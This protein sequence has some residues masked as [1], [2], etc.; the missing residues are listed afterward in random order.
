MTEKAAT[1][2][3]HSVAAGASAK[4]RVLTW[5]DSNLAVLFNVPTVVLLAGLVAFPTVLVIWTSLTDWQLVMNQEP[6]F[7]GLSNYVTMWQEERWLG[8]IFNTFYYAIV[9]LTGQFVLGMATALL[10]N[11]NFAGKSFY[12]SIWMMPMISM[13]VAI[14]LVW[15]IMFNTTYGMLNFLLSGLGVPE[16][17]WTADPLIV[18][19]SLILVGIWQWTPFMT[20][21]LLAGLQSLP[22]DP[23]EAAK[24]DG[25]SKWRMLI[26]ITLP[27]MQG[28][29]LVALILRS[30]FAIKEFDIILTITTGGPNY[31]S[32][33]MNMNIYFN[34]F[35]YGYMGVSSAKGVI[36][37][38]FILVIQLVLVKLRRRQWSY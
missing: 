30:I 13:S 24:I 34:A 12:R 28:H 27:L 31:A 19:P 15:A 21:L 36:F 16:L 25:A 1:H 37:F 35:E 2:Q 38:A 8:G 17:A 23:F 33:T 9:S 26:H 5:L 22:T 3:L 4:D 11:R 10:F 7:V 18:M 6:N 20:L 29:I 32:E 14:S